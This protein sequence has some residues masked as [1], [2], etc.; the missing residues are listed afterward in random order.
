MAMID[1]SAFLSETLD[2]SGGTYRWM[3]PELLDPKAYGSNGH[4]TRE[5]DCYALGMVVYEVSLSRPSWR[6]LVDIF[7][8]VLTG[9]KP[10]YSIHGLACVPAIL[11]GERPSIPSHAESLGFSNTLC[12]LVQLCWS[13]TAITRPTARQLLDSLSLISSTWVPPAAYPIIV[14]DP[15]DSE[16]TDSEDILCELNMRDKGVDSILVTPIDV[17]FLFL[18][19]SLLF[20]RQ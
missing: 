10:F 13:E 17:A 14:V 5:S 20:I 12:G 7:N 1:L 2:S 16:S 6:S 11:R 18:S 15:S 8:Q 4:L 3:S 19:I 9:L